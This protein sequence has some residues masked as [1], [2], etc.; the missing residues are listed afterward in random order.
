MNQINNFFYSKINKIPTVPGKPSKFLEF[1]KCPKSWNLLGFLHC[2][3][4]SW[5]SPG[6]LP[7]EFSL[8]W[9]FKVNLHQID[10]HHQARKHYY[11]VC[12]FSEVVQS[13]RLLWLPLLSKYLNLY[14][15]KFEVVVKWNDYLELTFELWPL[16]KYF[17]FQTIKVI[18][19]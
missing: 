9:V 6:I 1:E 14:C 2:F 19:I 16:L 10:L 15:L 11:V 12:P 17:N 7:C 4:K 3:G 18:T 13:D 5:K 8:A